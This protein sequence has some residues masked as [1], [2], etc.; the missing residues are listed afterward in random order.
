MSFVIFGFVFVR[1]FGSACKDFVAKY[2]NELEYPNDPIGKE[3]PSI[4]IFLPKQNQCC[5][6][7]DKVGINYNVALS[8]VK[9]ER[10]VLILVSNPIFAACA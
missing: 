7:L 10:A 4:E 8:I 1:V 2:T 6:L 5:F 9:K 3:V